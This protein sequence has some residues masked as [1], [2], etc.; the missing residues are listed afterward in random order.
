MNPLRKNQEDAMH[1][2]KKHYYENK[3]TRG[4]LSMCC[5]SGKTRTFYEIM[6][7]CFEQ[8]EKLCI[9][10][11]SRILLVEN[12][13]QEILEYLYLESITPQKI[14][15]KVED[16]CIMVKVS[17]FNIENIKN[18]ICNK[19]KNTVGFDVDYFRN[20]FINFNKKKITMDGNT[21][22]Y[23]LNECANH[24]INKNLRENKNVIIVTTYDSLVLFY[25]ELTIHP[26]LLVFDESHNLVSN[27]NKQTNKIIDKDITK[28]NPQKIVFMTATPLRIVSN[29]NI[30]SKTYS[31]EDEQIFGKYFYEYSFYEGIRDKCILNFEVLCYDKLIAPTTLLMDD[32]KKQELYINVVIEQLLSSIRTFKLK[33]TIIYISNQ[34]KAKKMLEFVKSITTN[35]ESRCIISEQ[36]HEIKNSTLNWFKNVDNISKILIS[37]NIFDEGVDIPIC[38]SVLFAEPRHSETQIVQNI[39][40]SLRLH[41]T[42]E[43]AYVIIPVYLPETIEESIIHDYY[44]VINICDKL[45]TPPDGKLYKRKYVGMINERPHHQT[46]KDPDPLEYK[47]NIY[48]EYTNNVSFI[49]IVQRTN[50]FLDINTS[51]LRNE[52]YFYNDGY[53]NY[54]ELIQKNN[55][56]TLVE[57]NKFINECELI[58]DKRLPHLLFTPFISY[59]DLLKNTTFDYD[60]SLKY[61]GS[62]NLTHITS[63]DEWICYYEKIIV[64]AFNGNY[65]NNIDIDTFILLPVSPK[66]YYSNVWNNWSRYLSLYLK[67]NE[68]LHKYVNTEPSFLTKVHDNYNRIYMEYSYNIEPIYIEQIVKYV[69]KY[70]ELDHIEFNGIAKTLRSSQ[71]YTIELYFENN[72][73]FTID[74][75]NRVNYTPNNFIGTTFTPTI[76]QLHKHRFFII[77]GIEVDNI[78]QHMRDSTNVL[79]KYEALIKK[80]DN[81]LNN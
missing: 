13:I 6:K 4:I 27:N 17:N 66:E 44:D 35:V 46:N 76:N 50:L 54:K 67:E 32:N 64:D 55:C 11:T 71:K 21:R 29:N 61:L 10:A 3:E 60:S 75:K 5:G 31:M 15:F 49:N 2:F 34:T 23:L 59:G 53:L 43:K 12:V 47:Q 36:Y 42:K 45:R 80:M 38:D 22:F 74:N 39:G 25:N 41:P 37:V 73:I 70:C 28:I 18:N 81:I 30:V 48:E 69:K 9:Y 51:I 52:P 68:R 56:T 26:D 65:N 78:I 20:F 16:I 33:R 24:T 57:L 63:S 77:K 72:L 79:A 14:P 8:N 62:L 58:Q 7:Y 40:R 1:Y 19:L